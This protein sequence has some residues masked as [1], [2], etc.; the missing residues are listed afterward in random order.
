MADRSTNT[1]ATL[2][3]RTPVPQSTPA[4]VPAPLPDLVAVPSK[5]LW[6][7]WYVRRRTKP[8]RV[9]AVIDGAPA[10]GEFWIDQRGRPRTTIRSRD[11]ADAVRAINT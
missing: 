11:L 8:W 6:Q 1:R 10:R 7:V 5:K 3:R 4:T 9:I 2:S